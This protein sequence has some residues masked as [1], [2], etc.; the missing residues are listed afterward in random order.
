MPTKPVKIIMVIR[1]GTN[2]P[3]DYP[4]ALVIAKAAAPRNLN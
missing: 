4:S 1:E 2:L 3:F